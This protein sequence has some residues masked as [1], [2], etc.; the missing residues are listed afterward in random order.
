MELP[1]PNLKQVRH[2]NKSATFLNP[3]HRLQP[4]DPTLNLGKKPPISPPNFALTIVKGW[5]VSAQ[6]DMVQH[7]WTSFSSVGWREHSEAWEPCGGG[8]RCGPKLH[9]LQELWLLK[10]G[11][12]QLAMSPS[13]SHLEYKTIKVML[14]FFFRWTCWVSLYTFAHKQVKEEK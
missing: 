8:S 14:L 9:H 10:S 5:L 13:R 11:Q 3:F 1:L 2:L 7:C 12:I 4:T 6:K